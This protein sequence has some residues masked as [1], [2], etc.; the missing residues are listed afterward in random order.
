[1]FCRECTSCPT[2]G[3]SVVAL[4]CNAGH[5]PDH[6]LLPISSGVARRIHFFLC[7]CC[8]YLA[9]STITGE[10]VNIIRTSLRQITRP[11]HIVLGYRGGGAWH[12]HKVCFLS[13]HPGLRHEAVSRTVHSLVICQPFV[14]FDGHIGRLTEVKSTLRRRRQVLERK[15]QHTCAGTCNGK[16]S[17]LASL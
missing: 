8:R 14:V 15:L 4:T 9:T 2:R 16:V 3:Q 6:P 7:V 17:F 13:L 10:G 11:Q 5:L 12:V 1:M